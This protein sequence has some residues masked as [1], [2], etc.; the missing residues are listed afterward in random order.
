MNHQAAVNIKAALVAADADI[1]SLSAD[2]IITRLMVKGMQ[3]PMYPH[4]YPSDESKSIL[5]SV[6]TSDSMAS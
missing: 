5:S 4:A 3:L 6:V 2:S 1:E